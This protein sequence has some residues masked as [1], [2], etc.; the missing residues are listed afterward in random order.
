MSFYYGQRRKYHYSIDL[1]DTRDNVISAMNI[2]QWTTIKEAKKHM[3]TLNFVAKKNSLPRKAIIRK[4]SHDGL[5]MF[6]K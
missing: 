5:N 3:N 2:S 1:L 4:V 6:K